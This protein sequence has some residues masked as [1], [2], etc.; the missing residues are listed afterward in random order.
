MNTGTSSDD[1]ALDD[2][3]ISWVVVSISSSLSVG[4]LVKNGPTMRN[5]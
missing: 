1:Q 2:S 4:N 3:D 5:D